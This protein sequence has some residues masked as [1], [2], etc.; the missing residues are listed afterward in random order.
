MRRPLASL[1]ATVLG[2]L[3][4][5]LAPPA[6]A[7][8]P[9][10]PVT[11]EFRK[12][13]SWENGYQGTY[14]IRNHSR[15]TL[16]HWTVE[17]TLPADTGV[18]THWDAG[19]TREGARYTFRSAGYNG[20]LAPGASTTFGWIAQGSGLPGLCV[21]NRGGP[22]EQ[23]ADITPPTVPTGVRVIA[24]ES[25]A[26]TL[27]WAASADDRSPVVEYE[28]YVDG[29]R[30]AAL[31]GS[32][33][34]RL[35]GLAPAMTYQIQLLAKDLAGNRSA[36]S[37]AIT[38]TT[39]DLRPARTMP[40]APYVDM[41][42]WPTPD[43]RTLAAGSGL[44]NFS[45]G[46]IT[47]PTCKAMWFNY[48]DPRAG[49]AKETIDG[50]RSAGGDVKVTFGG[51]GGRELAQNCTSVDALFTE[52][53]AVVRQYGLRYADFDIEGAAIND[54]VSV[55]RRSAAL[56]RL[57]QAHPGLRISLTLPVTPRGLTATGISVVTSAREAGVDVDVVNVM[58]MDYFM[59]ID[60]G[61]AA[62]Q[63]AEATV[64]QLRALY[65][66]RSDTRLWSMLGITPM[67]GENDDHQIYDQADARQ[68]VAF[69]QSRKLGMIAFWD[70]TRDRNA[71]TGNLS[72]CTNIPQSPYEFSR[73]VAAYTG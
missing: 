55:D 45:L 33:S 24:V 2:F 63:A 59:P 7:T 49:W 72:L 4:L 9:L 51:A 65:P 32:T 25:E 3:T 5:L 40:T 28:I 50:L 39:G 56:A 27:A 10:V 57:Q 18:A 15:T 23:D 19:L 41:G 20:T 12:T 30:R 44:K 38:G 43:L 73:I 1:I 47:S 26:L 13:S 58:T 11:A 66:G 14:T 37:H 35:T 17:F 71:C 21:I 60:Y 46:A 70:V 69:A 68:L 52:Y 67:I 36:L 54:P 62:L 64:G 16:D 34:H 8:S 61:D 42:A 53:D 48:Y 29:V 31:T 6:S 22:C